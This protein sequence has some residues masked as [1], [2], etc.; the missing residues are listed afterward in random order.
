[1]TRIQ[2][3][4]QGHIDEDR[5]VDLSLGE[6]QSEDERVHV[7][8]CPRCC[9][10][11]DSLMRTI[12]VAREASHVALVAPGSHVW[13]GIEAELD[14]E[15]DADADAERGIG[16]TQP[17]MAIPSTE[18]PAPGITAARTA[19]RRPALAWLAAA[20]AAGVLLGTAGTVVTNRLTAQDPDPA[21]IVA[22]AE[23]DTL[24]TGQWRGA[25]EVS[26]RGDEV[27]LDVTVRDIVPADGYVE[28]WLINR[29]GTRLVSVGV[30][31]D[32]AARGSFPISRRLL[33]EGYVVVDLSR[34]LFDDKPQHSGDSIV[35]GSLT[36][37]T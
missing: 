35:R 37:R 22:S 28:V 26:E 12:G 23:L 10:S 9:E 30:L 16:V 31:R 5:L 27:T 17:S 11:L 8:G 36:D 2:I 32:G 19:R 15:L 21:R 13:S 34:E 20:C 3:P 18:S 33:D 6:A 24:D 29:D 7:A 25:A 14:A 1:M 4:W